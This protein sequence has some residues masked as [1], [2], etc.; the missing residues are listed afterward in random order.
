MNPVYKCITSFLSPSVLLIN[1]D[2]DRNSINRRELFYEDIGC[3][4]GA[5]AALALAYIVISNSN[6]DII[7]VEFED[8]AVI[9]LRDKLGILSYE[10]NKE[11]IRERRKFFDQLEK[12]SNIVEIKRRNRVRRGRLFLKKAENE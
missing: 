4:Y 2:I 3:M 12:A 9:K 8:D 7:S 5:A 11:E 6:G 1:Q 10:S